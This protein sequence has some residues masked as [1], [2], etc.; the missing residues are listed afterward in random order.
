MYMISLVLLMITR[1]FVYVVNTYTGL[2][3]V[4]ILLGIA[5]GIRTVYMSLVIP[6]YIPIE[7]LASASGIQMVTNGVILMFAGPALGWIRDTTG[8]YKVCIVVINLVTLCALLMW[9]AEIGYKRYKAN[10]KK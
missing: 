7:R 9:T 8:S 10:K 5:K 1:S 4:G 3:V 6:D 2:L